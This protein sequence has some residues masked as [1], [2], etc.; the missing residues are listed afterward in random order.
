[1]SGAKSELPT[2][3]KKD[4]SAEKGQSFKSRDLTVAC[5]MLCGVAFVTSFA[6]L[7]EIMELF[8]QAIESGFQQDIHQFSTQIIWMSLKLIVPIVFVCVLASALPTLLQTRFVIAVKAIK[9]NFDALNPVNGFKKLFSLRTVKDAVKALLYLTA[10]TIAIVVFWGN[11]KSVVLAQ[12]YATPTELIGIW[13]ELLMNLVLTCLGCA[14]L[15]IVLD[16]LAEY[17]LSIKDMKMEKREVKRERKDQDGN[18]EIK[19][20]RRELHSELLSEQIKSD[21]ENSR[22]IIANPTHIA[23]G[24][25]YK[26]DVVPIPF[27]SVVE[28]NQRALAVRRYAEKIGVPV[29]RDIALARRMYTTH[30]RYSFIIS[31]E[32]G[33]ILV[34]LNWLEAAE[35][36]GTIEHRMAL[37]AQD[38]PIELDVGAATDSPKNSDLR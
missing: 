16:A 13:Q 11:K 14:L 37:D 34:L 29:V 21:V 4:D 36:L 24:I 2:K 3:K 19:N 9:L 6:S 33:E 15:V 7:T 20:R 23:I 10:F 17:F 1:M 12:L 18:P 27:I 26:P 31:E 28:T 32:I 5:L 38:M 22:V 30:K 25:F 35:N 8:R